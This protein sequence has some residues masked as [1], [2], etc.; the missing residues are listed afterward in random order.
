MNTKQQIQKREA[1]RNELEERKAILME[2]ILEN[3]ASLGSIDYAAKGWEQEASKLKEEQTKLDS[4]SGNLTS[5]LKSIDAQLAEL[6]ETEIRENTPVMPIPLPDGGTPPDTKNDVKSTFWLTKYGDIDS[7]TDCIVK[8]IYGSKSNYYEA[9]HSQNTGYVN[10]LIGKDSSIT[11]PVWTMLKGLN[12]IPTPEELIGAVVKYD[13]CN[14]IKK[15]VSTVGY[16][17]NAGVMVPPDFVNQILKPLPGSTAIREMVDRRKTSSDTLVMARRRGGDDQFTGNVRMTWVNE[18]P[19]ATDA[20]T[21]LETDQIVIA[22]ETLS[23]LLQVSKHILE[24]S[25]ISVANEVTEQFR[26]AV[27]ITESNVIM[28]GN[29]AG[30]PEG[31]TKDGTSL[32]Q[33]IT[34]RQHSIAADKLFD[35]VI[36]L[37][38]DLP[39]QYKPNAT[40]FFNRDTARELS[41]AKDG[42][43]AYLWTEMRGNNAVGSPDNLRGHRWVEQLALPN[44]VIGNYPIIFGDPKGY[45]LA[46]RRAMT[47]TRYDVKPGQNVLDYELFHRVGGMVTQPWRFV[48]LEIIA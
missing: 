19:G 15:A 11:A 37:M 14:E 28:T 31:I 22:V 46:D 7:K 27:M 32:P 17:I 20:E 18:T 47:I 1:K 34:V 42:S 35:S 24:D 13:T 30:K 38:F 33:N 6:R 8:D 26:E 23:G 10:Y 3:S 48:A 16:N 21:T 43:G 2:K 12:V 29:G 39:S 40:W 9:R 5:S 25:P 36:N 41:V 45:T 4:E 44:I